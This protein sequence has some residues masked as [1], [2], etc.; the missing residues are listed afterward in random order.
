MYMFVALAVY[1]EPPGY[2]GPP[3]DVG[4]AGAVEPAGNVVNADEVG[5]GG[6]VELLLCPTVITN[7]T[8]V[9]M[10]ARTPSVAATALNIMTGLLR[11]MRWP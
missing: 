5:P 10:E 3:G 2:T 7:V 1:T 9:A 11:Q 8:I 6:G 4:L